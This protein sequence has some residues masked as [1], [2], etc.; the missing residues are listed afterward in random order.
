M[1]RRSNYDKLPVVPVGRAEECSLGWA[2]IVGRLKQHL[3]PG[4]AVCVECYPG[5]LTGRV[6]EGLR[7]QLPS[8]AFFD[9]EECLKTTE[10]LH[11]ILDPLLGEDRV[12]GQMS[13]LGLE[14]Y[15][16]RAKLSEMQA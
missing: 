5:V 12:F 7:A 10:E 2:A 14:D 9:A 3:Q 13:S 6:L 1:S 15:F 11:L 4:N 8:V 16:D